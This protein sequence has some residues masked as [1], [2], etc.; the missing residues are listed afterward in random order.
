MSALSPELQVLISPSR[1][2]AKYA[3]DG[4]AAGIWIGIRR[5]LLVVLIQGVAIAMTASHTVAAPLVASASVY[6]SSAVVVQ[7]AAASMLILAADRRDLPFSHALDLLF[8]GHAPWSLWL[9]VSAAALT[10]GT[11]VAGLHWVMVGSMIVPACL[12][13]RIVHGFATTVLG[14]ERRRARRLTAAHQAFVWAIL[15][16]YLGMGIQAVP[17]VVGALAR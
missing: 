14:V 12:T 4:G 17:R 11:D 8:L 16:G 2:Y 7:V 10:W 15:L 9:L 1:A 6:W 13:A 3:R 5:P